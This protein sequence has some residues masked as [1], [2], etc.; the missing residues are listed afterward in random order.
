MTYIIF[1]AG[2]LTGVCITLIFLDLWAERRIV[3]S[4]KYTPGNINDTICPS[5]DRWLTVEEA[6]RR[7][8]RCGVEW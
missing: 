1:L 6:N 2:A 5:C 8:C 3:G 4:L 7:K